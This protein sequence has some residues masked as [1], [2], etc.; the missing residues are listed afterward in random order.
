MKTVAV[1]PMKLNNR[2]LQN[3]NIK[4]FTNGSPLC[5]Y[6]LETLKTIK[7]IGEIYVYCSDPCIK[8]YL[9]HGI[10][11][12]ER[13]TELDLDSTSMPDVLRA[14]YEDVKADFYVMTYA[15]APFISASSIK[16]GLDAV[17]RGKFDS[18]F[19]VRK[20]Q[21]FFGKKF[22]LLTMI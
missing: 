10:I 8:K 22:P 6:K 2:R 18:S 20:F 9:P 4:S 7:K 15:S 11:F 16:K 21:D 5:T 13:S 1:V 12:L 3:K 19:A 17:L 14:C